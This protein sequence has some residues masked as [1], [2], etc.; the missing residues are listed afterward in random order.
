VCAPTA[1]RRREGRPVAPEGP[2]ADPQARRGSS[3]GPGTSCCVNLNMCDFLERCLLSIELSR[4]LRTRIH[5]RP[6]EAL[7]RVSEGD[8]Q[9]VDLLGG[10]LR[11]SQ[12]LL[13]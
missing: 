9:A 12:A 1:K 6:E 8:G 2:T 5:E 4:P 11:I 7:I 3:K 10:S 13:R